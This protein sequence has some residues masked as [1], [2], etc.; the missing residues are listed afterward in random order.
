MV[1][2]FIMVLN[3]I[4]YVKDE[5]SCMDYAETGYAFTF[6]KWHLYQ[7]IFLTTTIVITLIAFYAITR[8]FLGLEIPCKPIFGIAGC[9]TCSMST[10]TLAWLIIGIIIF[11]RL[12]SGTCSDNVQQFSLTYFML[13]LMSYAIFL[14]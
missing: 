2:P 10:V 5:S 6:R 7:G 11:F 4:F 8:F 12:P 3:F 9:Y 14:F 13:S 1:F